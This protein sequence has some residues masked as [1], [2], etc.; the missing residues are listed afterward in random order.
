MLYQQN[1][2]LIGILVLYILQIYPSKIAL[3]IDLTYLDVYVTKII[4]I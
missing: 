2:A 3:Q 4:L 1:N